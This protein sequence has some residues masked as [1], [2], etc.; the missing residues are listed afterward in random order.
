MN[1]YLLDSSVTAISIESD[2]D[3]GADEPDGAVGAIVVLNRRN[4]KDPAAEA[5]NSTK[6][7][8]E[9]IQLVR[10]ILMFVE[11]VALLIGTVMLYPLVMVSLF[12]DWRLPLPHC[13][14]PVKY[15]VILLCVSIHWCI[16]IT[17]GIWW[18]VNRKL[19]AAVNNTGLRLEQTILSH[20]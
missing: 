6:T 19:I 10:K 1:V 8:L 17:A 13:E 20:V 12:W 7:R 15:W 3:G 5:E 16:M 4:L 9:I 18:L 11:M 2:K 14:A